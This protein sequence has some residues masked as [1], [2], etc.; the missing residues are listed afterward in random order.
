MYTEGPLLSSSRHRLAFCPALP[1]GAGG[2]PVQ[3]EFLSQVHNLGDNL[4][5]SYGEDMPGGNC[6]LQEA[7]SK[8]PVLSQSGITLKPET[9]RSAPRPVLRCWMWT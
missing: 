6:I 7:T 2:I 4:S 9:F 3:N 8:Y 5:L 1:S